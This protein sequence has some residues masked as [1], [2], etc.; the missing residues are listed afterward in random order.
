VQHRAVGCLAFSA[1][2]A[3]QSY[4]HLTSR[5]FLIHAD[6]GST[7]CGQE[8]GEGFPLLLLHGGPGLS[9]YMD[10]LGSETH[11]WHTIS[12]QQR[13]LAPST[14]DGPF[15]VAQ[16][17]ADTVAVLNGLGIERAALLGHS[18]GCHLALQV[19]VVH[20]D[21]VAAL[22][23]IDPPGPSG[24]GGLV[25]LAEELE[26][27]L[28]ANAATRAEAIAARLSGPDPS[29]AD[30]T[31][32]LALRWPGYFADPSAAPPLPSD[33]RVSLVSNGATVGSLFEALDGTFSQ[34]LGRV[35]LPAVFVLGG[36]SP[37]RPRNGQQAAELMP[38]AE[39]V[40]VAGAGHLPWVEAPGCVAS[41]LSRL[42]QKLPRT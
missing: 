16:H 25:E 5:S 2:S 22:L 23:L 39:V 17:V 34:S 24:D 13:G 40:I 37:L 1:T 14:T 29:D 6:G 30:A 26:K 19:V 35:D 3:C 10:L 32:S 38:D 7:L 31:E 36:E 41:A 4:G 8:Q 11:G 21:R 42:K 28:P 12:Y 15:T 18:W 20:P 9:D 33:F 27:R